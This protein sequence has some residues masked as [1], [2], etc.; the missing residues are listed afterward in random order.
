MIAFI[1]N[2]GVE[3]A[4]ERRGHGAQ[5]LLMLHGWISARRMWYDVVDRLD[6]AR[7]TVHLLDFRGSGLSD[8]P[9]H[10]HDLEG[11]ASDVRA[12]IRAIGAP[13]TL[14][15]HSM[16]GKVAQYVASER[17]PVLRRLVLVAPGS[18]RAYR[19]P[20]THRDATLDAF[21]SRRKIE[22]FQRAAMA[23]PI[24]PETME[25]IVDDALT[26]QREAWFGW[27]DRGRTVD[28]SERLAAIEIPTL[29]IAGGK[30]PLGPPARLKREVAGAIAGALMVTLRN[31]GHNLPVEAPE[32][33]AA[34]VARFAEPA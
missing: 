30:D 8:R 18:A 16:G 7:F 5:Q 29:C 19:F 17:P 27:Y 9:D 34:A 10:G 11:Y 23:A 25:R 33:I 32:E 21:G 24:A 6:P 13:L 3:L 15:G 26:G 4:L 12:A 2:D 22:A 28:F 14:V 20:A 31:A 1:D